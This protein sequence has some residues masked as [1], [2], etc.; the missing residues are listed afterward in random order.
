MISHTNTHSRIINLTDTPTFEACELAALSEQVKVRI[1]GVVSPV[2]TIPVHVVELSLPLDY[3]EELVEYR[4]ATKEEYRLYKKM[5]KLENE[6]K[7]LIEKIE[8]YIQ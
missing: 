2:V 8:A 4:L 7:R 6:K 5:T 1:H 3:L